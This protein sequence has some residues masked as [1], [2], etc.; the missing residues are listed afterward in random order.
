MTKHKECS[1]ER[2]TFQLGKEISDTYF[3]C[4]KS[5]YTVFKD[6]FAETAKNIRDHEEMLE[7]INK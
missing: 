7:K 5:G 1:N 2:S 3:R 4:V 6:I